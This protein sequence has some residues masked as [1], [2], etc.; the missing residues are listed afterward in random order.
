MKLSKFKTVIK[1]NIND[2][3]NTVLSEGI[4]DSVI[5]YIIDKLVKKKT[6]KYFEELAKDPEFIEAKKRVKQALLN[7]DQSTE[8][9]QN[10]RDKFAAEKEEF[11]KKYGQKKADQ[12]F[13][14]DKYIYGL[15]YRG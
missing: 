9:Y 15:K 4:I 12:V 1:E 3:H 6:K 8:R 14:G 13:R 10:S 7:I 5:S 11:V 2:K